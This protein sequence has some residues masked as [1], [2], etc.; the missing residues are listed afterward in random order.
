[1]PVKRAALL[2]FLL[3]IS[4][5]A[6]IGC[7]H[8]RP[9]GSGPS[10]SASPS[11]KEIV[12]QIFERYTEAVGGQ[13]AIESVTSFKTR[14]TF[15]TSAARIQGT[16]EAWGKNPN[17]NVMRITFPQFEIKKGFDGENQ[18]VQT[19]FGT[20]SSTEGATEMSQVERDA[21]VYRAGQL[22]NLY[23]DLKLENKVRLSGRD[24]YLVEGIPQRG[25]SEK[26]FFDTETGLLVRWDMVRKVPN[27][28]HVFVKVHLDDYREVDG[29]KVPFKVRFAFESF[30]FTLKLDE[31]KHNVPIDD[32]MFRKP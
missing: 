32:A 15:E 13:Q 17:K 14:G 12:E 28:G 19:P 7:K 29:L 20:F 26:L 8:L 10:A 24:V 9:G 25:P 21:D 31:L 16:F 30:D 4:V 2:P 5:T 23:Y 1:M 18:W 22:K 6:L 3:A 27:R 11:Q